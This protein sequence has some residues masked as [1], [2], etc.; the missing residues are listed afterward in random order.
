MSR[1]RGRPTSWSH[2]SSASTPAS[3]RTAC[4][5]P[6]P[7]S[8]AHE[9]SPPPQ[10]RSDPEAPG[11]LV[12]PPRGA[13]C[14][15]PAVGGPV[16][17]GALARPGHRAG[18]AP[19][20]GALAGPDAADPD[21]GLGHPGPG[22]VGHTEDHA[23]CLRPGGGGGRADL[24]PVRAEPPDRDRLVS[25]CRAAAGDPHRG[26]GPVDHHLGARCHAVD[27]DLC[28][29]VALFPIISNTTLGLRSIEPDLQNYFRLNH[30]TRWQSLVRLRIPSA[31]PYF[32]GGLSLYSGLA[33]IGAV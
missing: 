19:L 20:P 2:P 27:G 15:L 28:R 31:L 11:G 17:A 26:G 25:L 30:A 14:G 12:A 6:A 5:A 3:C 18:A 10:G 8:P 9:P 32:F 33:L 4:C 29:L 7:R 23:V 24:L 21:Q 1:T 16:P 13:A 22:P